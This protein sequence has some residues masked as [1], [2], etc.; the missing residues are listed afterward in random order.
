MPQPQPWDLQEEVKTKFSPLDFSQQVRAPYLNSTWGEIS[1]KEAADI[2]YRATRVPGVFEQVPEK[3]R[4]IFWFRS[5]GTSETLVSLQYGQWF[6]DELVYVQPI[7]P[8]NWAWAN[9]IPEGAY[10]F[11]KAEVSGFEANGDALQIATGLPGDSFSYSFRDKSMKYAVIQSHDDSNLT[12]AGTNGEM[13]GD[14]L[15][16]FGIP[17]PDGTFTGK[18]TLEEM[19]GVKPGSVF[20][21]GCYWGVGRCDCVEFGSYYLTKI[22]DENG[23]P[24][25]PYYSEFLGFMGSTKVYMW[26]GFASKG[27]EED[28]ARHYDK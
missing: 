26:T 19:E 2:M 28:A 12:V 5:D 8:F 15:R 22:I 27:A 25:E 17:I 16:D 1:A 13:I 6:A 9:G 14:S 23:A 11:E 21:R 4:G 24:L 7:S 18:F 20:K 3:F 10:G